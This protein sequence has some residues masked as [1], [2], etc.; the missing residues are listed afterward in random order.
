MMAVKVC[1]MTSVHQPEDGR[2]FNKECTSLAKEGYEV[3]LIERGAT[4]K[5]NGVQ[6]IGLG[7]FKGNR[8]KRFFKYTR[9][10]YREALKVNA[11]IYHLHDPEL[12]P[13]ALKLKRKG[14]KVVFDRHEDYVLQ[15]SCKSYFPS[16]FAL[17]I[18]KLY[19]LYEDYI[20][21]R[22]DAVI[23][24]CLRDGK[25]DLKG[26]VVTLDNFPL[27]SELYDHYNPKIDKY[28]RSICYVGSLTK[29]RGIT[30]IVKAAYLSN[31]TAYLAGDFNPSEYQFELEMLPE[32]KAVRYLG[33]LNRLQV[34]D[35]LQ[36]CSIGLATIHNVGQ[37]NTSDNLPTKCYEYMSLG[38]PVIFTKAKFNEQINN[39]F[40]F[41]LCVDAE[42]ANEIASAINYLFN[43]NEEI[44]RMGKN[45][46]KAVLEVFN[47]E[48]EK[49]KLLDLYKSLLLNVN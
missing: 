10:L 36:R 41:G 25:H 21:N 44:R 22:I 17:I 37:Y 47:W 28:E 27:L 12:L 32:S 38:L 24:P 48:K 7:E 6:I 30:E 16:W 19:K 15:I 5:K 26:R 18:S 29:S 45:G 20:F 4:Y 35:L 39:K 46:R 8:F 2:I 11:D 42:N 1:H 34:L 40:C 31:A 14:K 33:K 43:H 3:Y 49:D 13:Y 9:L 23:I